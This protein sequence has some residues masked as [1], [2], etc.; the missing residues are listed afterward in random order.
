MAKTLWIVIGHYL[1]N[2]N[3]KTIDNYNTNAFKRLFCPHVFTLKLKAKCSLTSLF[4]A[5]KQ[6][7]K[8][9]FCF[10]LK[11]VDTAL[12]YLDMAMCNYIAFFFLA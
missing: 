11:G 4:S 3:A 7:A 12:F 10:Y 8:L 5:L 9:P 1:N 6:G 2:Q